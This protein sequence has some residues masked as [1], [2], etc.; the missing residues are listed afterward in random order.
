MRIMHSFQ[1]QN[2]E[3]TLNAEL[4]GFRE[5]Y[6]HAR[7]LQAEE[8]GQQVSELQQ[9]QAQVESISSDVGLL[10][11][12]SADIAMFKE[13]STEI[14]TLK[15]QHQ[16][17]QQHSVESSDNFAEEVRKLAFQD[18]VLLT[19]V[20]EIR[21]DLINLRH[22]DEDRSIQMQAALKELRT[23]HA[24]SH[25]ELKS[26]LEAM[27]QG[28]MRLGQQLKEVHEILEERTHQLSK[29]G[30]QK[31][32][33]VTMAD[34]HSSPQKLDAID[35][36]IKTLRQQDDLLLHTVSVIRREVTDLRQMDEIRA[37]GSHSVQDEEEL[38]RMMR[39]LEQRIEA[40][41][42]GV[43]TSVNGRIGMV[44]QTC[45]AT[46]SELQ[47]LEKRLEGKTESSGFF[48]SSSNTRGKALKDTNAADKLGKSVQQRR[49]AGSEASTPRADFSGDA[50]AI[51]RFLR[52][53]LEVRSV[54][55][56]YFLCIDARNHLCTVHV[57][58]PK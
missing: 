13:L 28:E 43:Q 8:A 57:G 51:L 23:L 33:A 58:G 53:E 3:R 27:S 20:S 46:S 10:K 16:E 26:E 44:E 22:L 18:E 32:H 35:E 45:A 17:Q 1:V 6:Q 48:S 55:S 2:W 38:I 11:E 31:I 15:H 49:G 25:T 21:Q 19:T 29:T 54:H 39:N 42:L 52:A 12:L 36:E 5:A 30:I 9:L 7:A 50:P 37:A 14:A 47:H 24:Q 40:R 41:L 56:H 34:S 4:S